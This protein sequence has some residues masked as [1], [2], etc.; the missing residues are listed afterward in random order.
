MNHENEK[1]KQMKRKADYEMA[2]LPKQKKKTPMT[3][4]QKQQMVAIQAMRTDVKNIHSVKQLKQKLI[5]T[6]PRTKSSNL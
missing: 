2:Q 6:D 4:D 3:H 1:T 5:P